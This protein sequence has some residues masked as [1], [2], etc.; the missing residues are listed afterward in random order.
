[1]RGAGGICDKRR[2]LPVQN[3]E[4]RSIQNQRASAGKEWRPYGSQIPN[5]RASRPRPAGAGDVL[6][7]AGIRALRTDREK[8]GRINYQ[9]IR[10][11][12]AIL[13]FHRGLADSIDCRIRAERGG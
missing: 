9:Q 11:P 10:V 13:E 12:S 2:T 3:S 6:T 7:V 4:L 8:V 5:G 1:M